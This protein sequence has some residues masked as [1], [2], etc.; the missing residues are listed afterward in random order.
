MNYAKPNIE[1]GDCLDVL[2]GYEDNFVDLIVTSPP[3]AERRKN[4]YGGIHADL[5]VDWFLAR[6]QEFKRVLKPKGSLVLNIKESVVNGERQT[7]VIELILG[8]KRQG[9]LWTEEYIW[10]KKNA[11]PGK[12]P[13]RFRDSWERLLHFTKQKDFK[14]FQDNVKVPVGD[15]VKKRLEN[16]SK[17]DMVR[18]KSNVGSGFGT[19]VSNWVSKD[20]VYPSNV[21]NLST[22]TQNKGHSAAYPE[23][24]PTWFIKLFTEE[25]DMVLDPFAGSGTTLRAAKKINRHSI[26]IDINDEYVNLMYDNLN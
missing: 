15:W 12:W 3:Y 24:L 4:I 8:M 16:L 7:Y 19:N 25:G 26:G 23:R 6:S 5:Y 2:M 18:R 13:N 11:C 14:M 20:T 10:H 17:A 21:L 22:E 9:W 1:K